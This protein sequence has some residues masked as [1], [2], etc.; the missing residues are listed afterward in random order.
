MNIIMKSKVTFWTL[1]A[2]IAGILFG[3]LCPHYAVKMQPLAVMFLRMIK[4]ILAPLLFSTLV[5][6]IAGHDDL[7]SL[8]KLGLKTFIYFEVVT[9]IALFLGLF[10]GNV[11]K[12]GFGMSD[13]ADP[14][15]VTMAQEFAVQ[16]HHDSVMEM[17]LNIF[18]TSIADAMATGNLLQIVVFAI[19]FA[20]AAC[21]V[22]EKAKPVLKVLTSVSDI[23]FKF[24]G[25]VMW[26]A[27]FGVFGAMATTIGHSGLSV[28]ITYLKVLVCV[29]IALGL[30]ILFVLVLA[31]K[32][33]KI[34]FR[35]L[36]KAL[37]SPAL[38]AFST[39]S[40]EAA[41]PSAMEILEEFGAPKNIVGFVMP[42][43][44]TFNLDGS[45]L[46][47][48]LAVLFCTQLV[49]IDMSLSQQLIIVLA[50]MLT[51]KGIAGVPRVG[52]VIL[53]GTLATF[54]YPLIGVAVLLGIDQILDMGRTT[55]NLIGNC[56]ATLVI[57]RWDNQFD[58]KKMSDYL[59][60][61]GIKVK[62]KY[63]VNE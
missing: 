60:E 23:M 15:L 20:L 53:A 52:L 43:G 54:N 34:P 31:C 47:L 25:Y 22:G 35:G 10:V 38:L 30:F 7:K 2:L 9:T 57:A 39:A 17:V 16:G 24:T 1:I 27:P 33:V 50:L 36:L 37:Y 13:E 45:T 8:G 40:S 32:I 41:L 19:F 28:L 56:V 14:S 26:F 59:I 21:A 49:G 55:V 51:S 44:Y 6:G 42:A 48:S 18:P 61:N 12:P 4:M 5:I 62:D 11:M 29:V 58:Y 46:Y 63:L 3:W